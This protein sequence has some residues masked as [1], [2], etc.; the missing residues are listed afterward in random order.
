VFTDKHVG[1]NC[2]G[3]MQQGGSATPF[4]RNMGTKMASKAVDGLM[5]QLK[6]AERQQDGSIF[7]NTPESAVMMGVIRRQYRLTPL[8]ALKAETDFE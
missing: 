3:H 5:E 4:D 2:S 6:L 7:I 8:V 1:I